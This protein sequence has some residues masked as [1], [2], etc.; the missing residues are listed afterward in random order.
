MS[1][2]GLPATA[3]AGFM[4]RV[5][6]D[7]QV[8]APELSEQIALLRVRMAEPPRFLI[9]GGRGTGVSTL[10][11]ALVGEVGQ[12]SG[13]ADGPVLWCA[14]DRPVPEGV[15][16]CVQVRQVAGAALQNLTLIDASGLAGL[17]DDVTTPASAEGTTCTPDAACADAVVYLVDR[18]PSVADRERIRQLGFGPAGTVL[19][20]SRADEFGAGSLGAI[21]PVADAWGYARSLAEDTT[22][23]STAVAV[24][25]LL[26]AAA[27]V[28]DGADDRTVRGAVSGP[29]AADATGLADQMT[30][31]RCPVVAAGLLGAQIPPALM[32]DLQLVG[33][34]GVLYGGA[35]AAD[36]GKALARWLT[37]TSGVE[38]LRA[39]LLGSLAQAALLRR[40]ARILDEA[41]QLRFTARDPAAVSAVLDR[42]GAMPKMWR[43]RLFPDIARLAEAG[44][45]A[46][47]ALVARVV[48]ADSLHDLARVPAGSSQIDLLNGLREQL[49]E[50]NLELTGFTMPVVEAAL[51]AVSVVLRRAIGDVSGGA[52][53]GT[54]SL[55][56]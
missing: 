46:E 42:A 8:A 35:A 29:A 44:M 12:V 41:G 16:V 17:L 55:F 45:D 34:Y 53:D 24:S 3:V 38:D 21:D 52:T 26:A 22:F 54:G 2:M 30:S 5:L 43:I 49:R 56:G 32:A 50:V 10:V 9:S 39:V 31:Y 37:D 36:G 51:T 15:P 1:F 40:S 33:T 7:L 6:V 47:A 13:H 25:P 20:V 11:R 48:D 23:W 28:V 18:E 19:I 14:A 4:D 27:R